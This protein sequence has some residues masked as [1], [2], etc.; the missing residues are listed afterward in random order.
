[1]YIRVCALCTM[2]RNYI[3]YL[4]YCILYKSRSTKTPTRTTHPFMYYYLLFK[5]INHIPINPPSLTH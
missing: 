3:Q 5:R 2:Q 4:V 1:M